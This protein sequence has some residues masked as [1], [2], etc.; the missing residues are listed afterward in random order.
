MDNVNAL[1]LAVVHAHNHRYSP[2]VYDDKRYF[3]DE[4]L[5]WL[6]DVHLLAGAMSEAEWEQMTSQAKAKD[7]GCIVRN[8][9]LLS[10]ERL[11]TEVPDKVLSDLAL[12]TPGRIES[13]VQASAIRRKWKNFLAQPSWKLRMAYFAQT[14]FP[15]V[16]VM[17]ERYDS[18]S[19][20]LLPWFYLR[21]AVSAIYRRLPYKQR[22]D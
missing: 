8:Y 4:R 10:V 14:F 7:L 16:S 13:Y 3:S 5:I 18:D 17:R 15:P 2:F 22:S 6:Y 9:L 20:V 1:L 19:T 12:C 11:A 21:R